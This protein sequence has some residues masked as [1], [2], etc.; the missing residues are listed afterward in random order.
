VDRFAG[1]TPFEKRKPKAPATWHQL[2]N[3]IDALAAECRGSSRIVVTGSLRLATAFAVGAS[4]RMVTNTDVAVVQR[5]SLWSSDAPYD[6]LVQPILHEVPIGQG[7]E[8]AVA[9]A[10]AADLTDDVAEYLRTADIAVDRLAV[11]SLAGEPRD[12]AVQ[13]AEHACAIAVGVR[14]EVRKQARSHPRVHLFQAGPMGVALLLGHRWNR[15]A[16]TIVYE[17]LGSHDGYEP[18]FHVS[19]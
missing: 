10:I 17:D 8:L 11:L 14:N 15:V 4:L 5:G 16:P 18:A 9:V 1:E 19:A 7:D 2:Q 3:D 6:A 13:S 12:S